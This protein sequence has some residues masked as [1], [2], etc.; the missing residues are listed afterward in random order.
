MTWLPEWRVT[1]GDD[2]YTTVTSVSFASGRLDID[3]QATAGYCQVEI[4]NTTGADFTINVTEEITLELKNS[5]GTYVTV[6]G[7]EVSDFNI[8]VKSPDETGFITTGKILGIGSLAKLT[9]A[10]FNTALAEGLDGA[11]I[12]TILG[13]ALNLSWAEVTPTT[14]CPQ[15]AVVPLW[16]IGF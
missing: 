13:S 7:G 1:V 14:K 12:A 11:Q 3:R 15:S 2:V 16:S 5:S 4:V 8:G 10:V 6:F 9:K